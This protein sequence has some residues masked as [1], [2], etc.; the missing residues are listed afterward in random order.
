MSM[1]KQIGEEL[2]ASRRFDM[3][4]HSMTRPEA[5]ALFKARE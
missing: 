5:Q 4:K 1:I 3:L 2:Y